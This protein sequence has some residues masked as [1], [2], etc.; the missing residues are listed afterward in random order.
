ECL[1]KGIMA[2]YPIVDVKVSLYDG[3]YHDVDSSDMA[4][5]IAA[6][7]GLQKVFMEAHPILLEPIMNVEVTTPADHAGDVIGDLNSRRDCRHTTRESC[8][9]AF[10]TLA[11]DAT[12]P[13]FARSR[14]RSLHPG[15]GSST[16]MPTS[17]IT[18]PSSRSSVS[19]TSCAVRRSHSGSRPCERSTCGAITA[20][21][22]DSARS[23]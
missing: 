20:F 6:S 5:Q 17:T 21:I 11:R 12:T 8:L 4:F 3:S 9:S 23:T 15:L 10:R 14:S 2:G 16:F 13:S 19:P 1:K 7:I 22:R 18:A